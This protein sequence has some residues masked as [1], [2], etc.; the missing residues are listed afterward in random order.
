MKTKNP[1]HRRG[2]TL[3]ELLTV[4]AIIRLLAGILIPTTGVVFDKVKEA[5]SKNTFSSYATALI[6]YRQDYGIFPPFTPLPYDVEANQDEFHI[7]LSG[8][9]SDGNSPSSRAFNRT[10]TEYYN[11]S[12]NDCDAAGIIS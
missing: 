8:K 5:R 10:L 12:E 4:I 1:T 9:D 6:S 2:F 7:A 11:F 3:I